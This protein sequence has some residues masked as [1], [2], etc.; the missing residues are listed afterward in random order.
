[1]A[2]CGQPQP[3]PLPRTATIARGLFSAGK[4]QHTLQ[5]GRLF[6]WGLGYTGLGERRPARRP[7]RHRHWLVHNS[8]LPVHLPAPHSP[9]TTHQPSL[10]AL[11][12][13][14][15]PAGAANYFLQRGWEVAG[16]CRSEGKVDRLAAR[17]IRAFYFDPTEFDNLG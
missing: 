8:Y 5:P 6:V 1:M 10:P 16:T 4:Q 13:S 11:P 7:R 12:C 17:G 14:A 15:L 2:V 9:C 3:R